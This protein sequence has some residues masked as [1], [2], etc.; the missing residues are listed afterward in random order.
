MSERS[1]R[2]IENGRSAHGGTPN[3]AASTI[4]IERVQQ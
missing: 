4:T 3:E 1:E 2:I